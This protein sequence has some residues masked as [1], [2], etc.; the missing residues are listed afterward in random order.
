M[1]DDQ[2]FYCGDGL[3]EG[4]EECDDGQAQV[5]MEAIGGYVSGDRGG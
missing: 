2:K 5:M 1:T 4:E 3:V